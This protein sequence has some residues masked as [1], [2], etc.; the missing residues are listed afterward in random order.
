MITAMSNLVNQ[1]MLTRIAELSNDIEVL[2]RVRIE[3]A[4]GGTA[5]ATLSAGGGSKS[6]T[7]L[8]LDKVNRLIALLG[9]ELK[10][11]RSRLAGVPVISRVYTVRG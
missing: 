1:K 3:I 5:S 9:S 2:R 10:A 8:D 7:K 4:A 6:Y 11:L